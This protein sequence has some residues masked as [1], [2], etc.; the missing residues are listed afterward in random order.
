MDSSQLHMSLA[1]MTCLTDRSRPL[2]SIHT[3]T[4]KGLYFRQTC[5]KKC[6]QSSDPLEAIV[7]CFGYTIKRPKD[8][9][10]HNLFLKVC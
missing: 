9:T 6:C 7:R 1:S 2:L 3:G 8:Q 4:E 10:D 5:N